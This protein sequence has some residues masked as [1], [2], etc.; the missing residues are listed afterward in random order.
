M[1]RPTRSIGN[2]NAENEV[3]DLEGAEL[4]EAP[5]ESVETQLVEVERGNQ[6]EVVEAIDGDQLETDVDQLVDH[7]DN[8]EASLDEGGMDPVA[9]RATEIAVEDI[10]NRWNFKRKTVGVENYASG[11]NRVAA[12]RLGLESIIDAAK[13]GIAAII[14]WIKRRVAQVK[15]IWRKYV[16]AGKSI[17]SRAEKLRARVAKLTG[18]P[19]KD[20]KVEGSKVWQLVSGQGDKLAFAKARGLKAADANS[21]VEAFGSAID[22][23][24][25]DTTKMMESAINETNAPRMEGVAAIKAGQC[26]WELNGSESKF[27]RHF[28]SGAT[29]TK[30]IAAFGGLILSYKQAL[31][32]GEGATFHLKWVAAKMSDVEDIELDPL[33]TA[34][35]DSMLDTVVVIGANLEDYIRKFSKVERSFSNLE[36]AL[37]KAEA[38]MGKNAAKKDLNTA[39]MKTDR[40][41]V[42]S[43]KASF[44]NAQELDKIYREV[45]RACAMGSMAY[46]Q[47]S[48]AAYKNSDD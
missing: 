2:E 35:M 22:V 31:P 29:E 8:V 23:S 6:E 12:T 18:A 47:A 45:A 46:V 25:N 37:S 26:T 24:V 3:V 4:M 7:A 40:G 27:K 19:D 17:K 20:E 11:S 32:G 42:K 41:N 30:V 36:R 28:P 34:E 43:A 5:Q 38:K 33:E 13:Q 15:E 44:E 1:A 39:T 21:L 10:C 9:A 14:E 16:N 48:F